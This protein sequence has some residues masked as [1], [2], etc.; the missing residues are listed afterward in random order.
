MSV[1]DQFRKGSESDIDVF[2]R[3]IELGFIKVWVGDRTKTMAHVMA[4][5]EFFP[6]VSQAKKAGW[7]KPIQFGKIIKHKIHWIALL[8]ST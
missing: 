7:D 4:D 1:W 2:N 8:S 5:L 6:S 3:L